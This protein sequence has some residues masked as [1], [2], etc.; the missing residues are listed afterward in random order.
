[1]NMNLNKLWEIVED[2]GAWSAAVHGVAEL[3]MTEQLNDKRE[4]HRNPGLE[5]SETSQYLPK[6]TESGSGLTG[7]QVSCP[8][9][10]GFRAFIFGKVRNT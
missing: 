2:R 4:S 3:D 5:T 10:P 8:P 1:M 6:I 7:S 9:A